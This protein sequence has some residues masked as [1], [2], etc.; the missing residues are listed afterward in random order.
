MIDN[1]IVLDY[2]EVN[3][4]IG[5]FYVSKIGWKDL[6]EI[7]EA[8]QR[9]IVDETNRG[10]SFDSLLGIQRELSPKR[11]KDIGEYVQTVD[12]TF[13]T[14]IIL[15]IPSISYEVNGSPIKL[16]NYEVFE[17][18]SEIIEVPNIEFINGKMH[19]RK[20]KAI[21][22]ILD[23]QH[24]I[25]G[26]KSGFLNS[27]FHG[28]TIF[29]LNITIFIDLDIDDQAQVFSV[30]NKAQTKVNKSLVYDLYE[31]AKS[32]SPQKTAH[33]IVRL[34][35]KMDDSPFYRK[36]KIL[37]KAIDKELE[38]IAQATLAELIIGYISQD[39]IMDRDS[40]KREKR[41]RNYL[42]QKIYIFR[43]L[44][45][46]ENDEMIMLILWDFFSAVSK[47]W[48]DAWNSKE[49]GNILNKS[50]GII[51]LFRLLKI[52]YLQSNS[53]PKAGI[54]FYYNYFQMVNLKDQ[55]FNPI[56]YVPG[57]SGQSKLYQKFIQEMNL[58][59]IQ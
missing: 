49:K 33:D 46:E 8:D 5:T 59:A 54:S 51:S 57:S 56:N 11:I 27:L 18:K 58:G 24:R 2:I 29:E 10:N 20:S 52:L 21:A 6:I 50:T 9:K 15:A 45:I 12:A 47:R 1:S 7:A 17:N 34:L 32:R 48:P 37:G 44:F 35:N 36:I 40:L 16:Y 41:I 26:L 31:Y 43:T 39:P 14:S 13:P 3:Q 42:D 4:P 55:D 38:T 22:S 23:G 25:E 19:I 30:I 28:D 53:N